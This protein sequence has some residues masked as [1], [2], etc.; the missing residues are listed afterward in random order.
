MPG[1]R[2]LTP[3]EGYMQ[4][5]SW[6]IELAHNWATAFQDRL[7][8][9]RSSLDFG[10]FCE[11]QLVYHTKR[12]DAERER[13]ACLSDIATHPRSSLTLRLAFNTW[14]GNARKKML[15]HEESAK[16]WSDELRRAGDR[17][18]NKPST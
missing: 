2:H 1:L 7:E 14:A 9:E 15:K 18:Y 10:T 17:L 6:I 12:A 8:D 11:E 16:F 3:T 5:R 13:V 4:L